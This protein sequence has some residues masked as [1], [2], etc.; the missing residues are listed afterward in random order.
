MH[1]SVMQAISGLGAAIVKSQ[2]WFAIWN[3]L[4][5]CDRNQSSI[6]ILK[7][8]IKYNI[9]ISFFLKMHISPA[10]WWWSWQREENKR[11]W[12]ATYVSWKWNQKKESLICKSCLS[13]C[14]F[15]IVRWLIEVHNVYE[16]LHI[17][18]FVICVLLSY[19]HLCMEIKGH[20]WERFSFSSLS[21][22]DKA[23]SSWYRIRVT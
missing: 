6:L 12:V 23:E 19:P 1:N 11:T 8:Y 4:N 7:M 9:F 14:A 13:K 18:N 10:I 5:S 3:G 16:W 20:W 21:K 22:W 17:S 2:T 15:L